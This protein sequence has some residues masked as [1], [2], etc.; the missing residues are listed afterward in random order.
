MKN[1]VLQISAYTPPPNGKTRIDGVTKKAYNSFI[2]YE[3]YREYRDCGFTE[4]LF[5]G[6]DKYTGKPFVDSKLQKMLDLAQK[7]NLKA[8]VYDERILRLTVDAR[9]S[10]IAEK[11]KGDSVALE[12]Y[13]H[14][15]MRDYVTHPAFYGVS[16]CD[17]PQY[18]KVRVFAEVCA[19][20]RKVRPDCFIM[21]CLLPCIQDLG[22]A[23]GAFGAGERWEAYRKYLREFGNILGYVH[24][25]CYP[26]GMW[27]N[28]NVVAHQFIRNMQEAASVAGKAKLPF[29]MTVQS[30][31]SGANDE[32]RHVD[33]QDML[34]QTNLALGF[35]VSKIYYFTYWRFTTRTGCNFTSAIMN[36]DGSKNIYDEVQSCNF[37]LQNTARYVAGYTYVSSDVLHGG[38]G[39]DSTEEIRLSPCADLHDCRVQSDVLVNTLQKGDGRALMLLNLRDPFEKETNAVHIEF[40]QKSEKV[41]V[42]KN[43]EK[44]TVQTQNN[45]LD[46]LLEPGEAIWILDI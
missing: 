24:Y 3:R 37:N 33:L 26:F 9:E 21:T 43:G 14:D 4:I 30:F 11:F 28:K 39:N 45:A 36:D 40:A 15:C 27:E 34:W 12:E 18:S 16:V 32:L 20:V 10:V 44:L 23:E 35:G 29:H 7:A 25:D 13:V 46:F 1:D 5:A 17:E 22:L 31:S 42:V 2:T 6:E 38:N 41:C 8:V 19:A